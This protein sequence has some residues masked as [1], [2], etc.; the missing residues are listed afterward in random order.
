MI[1]CTFVF[2]AACEKNANV[3]DIKTE[4][5]KYSNSAEEIDRES[6]LA[7]VQK[8]NFT[9]LPA[10]AENSLNYVA[11]ASKEIYPEVKGEKMYG[12]KGIEKINDKS[13]YVFT[14]FTKSDDSGSKIGV[15]AIDTDGGIYVQNETTGEFDSTKTN[16]Q[17]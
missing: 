12:Y 11:A 17:K 1:A 5:N 13:C 14:V 3:S 8:E 6:F 7:D 2:C 15:I 16:L 10:N 9:K 4:E